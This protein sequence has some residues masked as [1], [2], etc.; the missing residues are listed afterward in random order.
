MRRSCA[1]G[2]DVKY[3][4]INKAHRRRNMTYWHSSSDTQPL[5]KVSPQYRALMKT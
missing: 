4:K 2:Q 5:N 1:P 3:L